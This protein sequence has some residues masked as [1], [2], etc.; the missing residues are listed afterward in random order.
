MTKKIGQKVERIYE[1]D[2]IKTIWTYDY[3]R[4]RFNPLYVEIIYKNEPK[5]TTTKKKS[6]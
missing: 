4:N 6:K 1:D 5:L 3:L 2:D